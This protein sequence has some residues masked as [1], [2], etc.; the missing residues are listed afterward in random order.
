MGNA[1]QA[2]TASVSPRSQLKVMA[3]CGVCPCTESVPV[4]LGD[5]VRVPEQWD[6]C[7]TCKQL[8]CPDCLFDVKLSELTPA[9]SEVAANWTLP[10]CKI[11]LPSHCARE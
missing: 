4:K 10:V 6:Y 8:I 11:C 3:L 7:N 2:A 1:T 5:I 9:I